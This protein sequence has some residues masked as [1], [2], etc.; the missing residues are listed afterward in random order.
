M[1][2][3]VDGRNGRDGGWPRHMVNTVQTYDWGSELALA[4]LQ[5]R[6]PTGGPEAEL[7]MGAHPSA[8][9]ALLDDDGGRTPLDVLL[10][11]DGEQLL[12]AEVHAAFGPR[13]P[14][15]LKV[16]AIAR[17]LSLQVHP[18]AERARAAHADPSLVPG[19]HRYVDPNP[20]PE[21]LYALGPV[22]ALC[23]FRTAAEAADLLEL[24]GL[25]RTAAVVESLRAG[26]PETKCLE[27]ALRVLVTWPEDDRSALAR[28]VGAAAKRLLATAGPAGVEGALPA[29]HRRALTW[30]ARLARLF[31]ADALVVAPLLL[32][33]VRLEP[34]DT[35]FVPAGAPHAY[36]H[37]LGVEIM[38]NSDNVL[39]AGLTHK[40][41]AVEE[42]LHVVDGDSRPVREVPR[43]ERGDVETVWRPGCPDFQLARARL[44][45]AAPA[46]LEP[47][48][49]GPQVLLA[50]GGSVTVRCE[51]GG[52]VTLGPG[53][54]AFVGADAGALTVTGPGELFR[55]AAC[56]D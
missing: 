12:G 43:V 46:R 5:G 22:D 3:H 40:T 20:K 19:E 38:S 18:D 55:A 27:D 29:A 48:G 54:S 10:A 7:W 39:R 24:L 56:L 9:S 50:T 30:T 36:L 11:E 52:I 8:P 14:F 15:L 1:V 21:L 26:G 51:D 42:L 34:G 31:P 44:A 32:D 2:D 25:G 13:L 28:E 53:R 16:L 17:P 45:D 4:R 6:A 49:P 47:L 23:G 37:G 41:V 33:L 35:L